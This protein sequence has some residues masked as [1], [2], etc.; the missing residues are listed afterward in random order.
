MHIYTKQKEV[1]YPDGDSF[2]LELLCLPGVVDPKDAATSLV[3]LHD[4]IL[5]LYVSC[6]PEATLHND[7]RAKVMYIYIYVYADMY[8]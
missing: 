6:G 5:W 1:E 2:M 7:E 4:S 3:A 8:M